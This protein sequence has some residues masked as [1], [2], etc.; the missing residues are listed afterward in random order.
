MNKF[1]LK[2]YTDLFNGTVFGFS[3]KSAEARAEVDNQVIVHAGAQ[4]LGNAD[5]NLVAEKGFSPILVGN[6]LSQSLLEAATASKDITRNEIDRSSSAVTVNGR[7]ETGIK[8]NQVLVIKEELLN[9]GTIPYPIQLD[10]ALTTDDLENP[11]PT[12]KLVDVGAGF[13]KQIDA[14]R[15]LK[16]EYANDAGAVT[17]FN[18]R[19]DA[20]FRQAADIGLVNNSVNPATIRSNYFTPFIVVPEIVAGIGSIYVFGE[21]FNGSGTLI[22]PVDANI[23]ITNYSPYSLQLLGLTVPFRDGGKVLFNTGGTDFIE[24]KTTSDINSRNKSKSG[25]TFGTITTGGTS[26]A[27]PT[28]T[29]ENK[30]S[31]PGT[32]GV[33]GF[34]TGLS[35][36][37]EPD[38]NVLGDINN[39]GGKVTLITG[40]SV[41]VN[42]NLSAKTIEIKAGRDFVLNS[43]GFFSSGGDPKGQ[44]AAEY[45]AMQ[46][47]FFNAPAKNATNIDLSNAA[48]APAFVTAT[49]MTPKTGGTILAGNNAYINAQ[50]LNIN[51]TIQSGRDENNVIIDA[52]QQT[53]IDNFKNRYVP[54][55]NKYLTLSTVAQSGIK[56]LYNAESNRIEVTDTVVRGGYMQ[57]MGRMFSTG[58]GTLKAMDGFGNI[59]ID[60]QT[61]YDLE[62][63][64][65]DTGGEG[66]EGKIVIIDTS[67]AKSSPSTVSIASLNAGSDKVYF[68][69]N[70]S[71]STGEEIVIN[72]T[73]GGLT[74][75]THYFVIEG[76]KEGSQY[77][78]KLATSLSDA[79]ASKALDIGD[80][81]GGSLLGN[82]KPLKT[83]YT[84][85][86]NNVTKKSFYE[87]F[88][89]AGN[90]IE[91][92]PTTT[93]TTGRV[94]P[95]FD[96]TS[97][98]RY[99]WKTGQGILSQITKEYVT[100]SFWGMDS[101]SPDPGQSPDRVE[102][103]VLSNT[104]LIE[105]EYLMMYND[106]VTKSFTFFGKTFT[107][108]EPSF[109]LPN[110]N[111]V[112]A[113]GYKNLTLSETRVDH[114]TFETSSGW[115]PFKTTYLHDVSVYD[116]N[117]K[118][119]H[120]FSVKADFAA[121]V[122][123]IGSDAGTIDVQ[124]VGSIIISNAVNNPKGVT[125]FRST[126]GSIDAQGFGSVNGNTI[127]FNAAK[128]IGV[129]SVIRT[130]L[131]G[132][133]S[134]M[135]AVTTT[136]P[137]NIQEI[138]GTLT[139]TNITTGIDNKNLNSDVTITAENSLVPVNTSALIRGR[140]LILTA[141]T[142]SI[143]AGP[144]L[145][146]LI[147]TDDVR[148]G[149][150]LA[151][152]AQNVAFQQDTG[153]LRV[154]SVVASAG[155]AWLLLGDGGFIDNNKTETYDTRTKDELLAVWTAARLT[156]SAANESLADNIAGYD[157]LK[158]RQYFNAYTNVRL[159]YTT[160]TAS[161]VNTATDT[162]SFAANHGYAN[163]DAVVYEQTEIDNFTITAIDSV[164]DTITFASDPGIENGT[165]VTFNRLS[166]TTQADGLT[167]GMRYFAF[168]V[169]GSTT[170]YKLATS[171]MDANSDNGIDITSTGAG[172]S[173]EVAVSKDSIG[174]LVSG[175]TYYVIVINDSDIKLSPATTSMKTEFDINSVD[176]YV[177]NT[178][179]T[180]GVD[181]VANTLDFAS[182]HGFATG[183][184]VV[185]QQ[186]SAGK[187]S[188][189]GLTSGATYYV[190]KISDTRI[191]LAASM[192][193]AYAATPVVIDL[194]SVGTGAVDTF[195][196][197][198]EVMD[199]TSDAAGSVNTFKTQDFVG[200][201]PKYLWDSGQATYNPDYQY[202]LLVGI[203][204]MDINND[205]LSY[206]KYSVS[207]LTGNTITTTMA[208]GLTTGD[209]VVYQPASGTTAIS[210][211]TPG[212]TY[213]AIVIG[214]SE[215]QLASSATNANSG[216]AIT[217]S[218]S[219]TG[220]HSFV[221]PSQ[222]HGYVTGDT[223][224]YQS[225]AIP[226]NALGGLTNGGS[227]T[228]EVVDANTIKFKASGVVVDLTGTFAGS[229]QLVNDINQY[230]KLKS[231]FQM[232][233]AELGFSIGGGLLSATR[234]TSGT[235]VRIES[236]NVRA[237]GKITVLAEG[238]GGFIGRDSTP[239]TAFLPGMVGIKTIDPGTNTLTM[240]VVARAAGAPVQGS[241]SPIN[242]V[243]SPANHGILDG[244][245]F[246]Y[247]AMAGAP[248]I[249][250][251]VDGTTYYVI[252]AN[253]QTLQL[254]ETL[255]GSV[256]DINGTID[257]VNYPGNYALT[258]PAGTNIDSLTEDQK[259]ALAAAEAGDVAMT[260]QVVSGVL[261]V[262][263][264]VYQRDDFDIQ[265]VSNVITHSTFQTF[266]GSEETINLEQAT[267]GG[268]MIIKVAKSILVAG[269]EL[270][271]IAAPTMILEAKAGTLGT[272]AAPLL[273]D[274]TSDVTADSFVGSSKIATILA[275]PNSQGDSRS[276]AAAKFTYDRRFSPLVIS[277]IN[278][279][280]TISFAKNNPDGTTSTADHGFINGDMVTYE[281]LP[282][283]LRPLGGV[284]G[285][286]KYRVRV[287]DSK[288]IM[289]EA[290]NTLG[291]YSDNKVTGTIPANTGH[292]IMPVD[293]VG[294]ITAR[295]SGDMNLNEVN[296]NMWIGATNSTTGVI[297]LKAVADDAG[298][299]DA[300]P[301]TQ[302]AYWNIYGKEIRLTADYIGTNSNRLDYEQA[303]SPLP[304]F[305]ALSKYDQYVRF[306]VSPISA[307]SGGV[308]STIC[309]LTDV[310]SMFG[311]VD[312][313]SDSEVNVK[314]VEATA[315]LVRINAQFAIKDDNNSAA[316]ITALKGVDLT[317]VKGGIGE[318][319]A[320]EM[321]VGT[322]GT[323]LANA[324]RTVWLTELTEDMN[325]DRITST[326]GTARLMADQSILDWFDDTTV[327]VE[328]VTLDFKALT[329]T[330][331]ASRNYLEVDSSY[332]G[333]V[334]EVLTQ[335]Y[336]GTYMD[337]SVSD[338]NLRNVTS[339]TDVVFLTAAGSIIDIK[340]DT[341]IKVQ[342]YGINLIAR[343]GSIGET[344]NDVETDLQVLTQLTAKAS[345]NVYL[346]EMIGAMRV[347]TIEGTQGIVRLSVNETSTS[348]EDYLMEPGD[349]VVAGVDILIVAADNLFVP[350]GA[351]MTAGKSIT[352]TADNPDA[353]DAGSIITV[354]GT[355][356]SPA[357]SVYGYMQRDTLVATNDASFVLANSKMTR[358]LRAGNIVTVFNLFTLEHAILTGG[359]GN[360]T[361]DIG[362]W[363]GTSVIDG[364]DG[365]DTI[366]ATTNANFVIANDKLQRTGCGDALLSNI[367]YGAFRG[368]IDNNTFDV[369]KWTL[370]GEVH[371]D[372]GID[373]INAANDVNFGLGNT[374]LKRTGMSDLL[375]SGLETGNM[376]GG[377]RDN[378]FTV[379]DWTGGGL[380][381]GGEGTDT[382]IA[383]NDTDF[384]LSDLI[385][386]RGAGKVSLGTLALTNVDDARLTGGKSANKFTVSDWT[387][388]GA[389]AGLVTDLGG[390][391][392]IDSLVAATD[393]DFTL[394]SSMLKRSGGRGDITLFKLTSAA[395]TGG[396]KNN[397]F[398]V[399]G[400]AGTLA[401]AGGTGSD[402]VVWEGKGNVVLGNTLL[403]TTAIKGTMAAI[404]FAE[405]TGDSSSATY[406]LNGWTGKATIE[407]GT[408][409]DTLMVR[410]IS[411]NASLTDTALTV[412]TAQIGTLKDFENAILYG[413]SASQTFN[414]A[415]WTN[416]GSIFGVGGTDTLL[417]T[418]SGAFLMQGTTYTAPSKA[419]W[420]LD[421]VGVNLT[422]SNSRDSFAIR[423]WTGGAVAFN[424]VS[425]HDSL[426]VEANANITIT[427]TLLT[428]GTLKSTINSTSIDS[429]TLIGGASANTFTLTG[430][431]KKASIDGGA[432]KDVLVYAGDTDFLL[433]ANQLVVG[434]GAS[435]VNSSPTGSIAFT[436]AKM[437][438]LTL[439]GGA[440]ANVFT[441][442]GFA[443]T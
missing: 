235:E 380:I 87:E 390:T 139:Y 374:Y 67:T 174:G 282:G 198:R 276:I 212:S 440:S 155:D 35:Q 217:L 400:W 387:G 280:G 373:V 435:S 310:K 23:S 146:A 200:G 210:G 228:V 159:S 57:L 196:S 327:D 241:V 18:A 427:P 140:K 175:S 152:A 215:F 348:G 291:V 242:D 331:G 385:L 197:A 113:Y 39:T 313:T 341:T 81:T 160:K 64:K 404:G 95:S 68:A 401:L 154:D 213:F 425:G 418:G 365:T 102:S 442:S 182:A 248:A 130:D 149:G 107:F 181:L 19:I 17:G 286:K 352:L 79:L 188:I 296:G 325:I 15:S 419:V 238:T 283:T 72:Q 204:G 289:L 414:V 300:I 184:A 173:F 121:S 135:E 52:S 345:A 222:T 202:R 47:R 178:Q 361:F 274:L 315:G 22:S 218:G 294:S 186:T 330:I 162:V 50:Y 349:S 384:L 103:R 364:V 187:D 10:A 394:S 421:K 372:L 318:N 32:A 431:N 119:Y 172:S 70:P 148:L 78:V 273:T 28:I 168:R 134:T 203:T 424:G 62:V 271:T 125:S 410:A 26:A 150:L 122:Q 392:V 110:N 45:K 376:T 56:V 371:G 183:D 275:D 170:A 281:F 91:V 439:T 308:P 112:F 42:G 236:A 206:G 207:G 239:V 74:S 34:V 229:H 136:G 309:Y 367:E 436:L 422:G 20:L 124:S 415:G 93:T 307:G 397:K 73:A 5:V 379:T 123:F 16:A 132:A 409:T 312:Y 389:L 29:V 354:S 335:S 195:T 6:A 346:K 65:L 366:I 316:D 434:K 441:M 76:A 370:P 407:A 180:G 299:L 320:I 111:Q 201:K 268:P 38:I 260:Y 30:W 9:N 333:T 363:T 301:D 86:G 264:T 377:R 2:A 44:W 147:E 1:N 59:T 33:N 167:V 192:M 319:G 141:T 338:M 267:S 288:K 179:T 262:M 382:L 368:G 138:A 137:I 290:A 208:H 337:E 403:T 396:T 190:I 323:V 336:L 256:V 254:S 399:S 49:Y 270:V 381:D 253:G 161:T 14:L 88:N 104:P 326:I 324:L 360:N 351:S 261:G 263:F 77:W 51:G 83:V 249:P 63:R 416:T 4:V 214:S 357:N 58:N 116:R 233:E 411:T 194:S 224:T 209:R 41:I 328:A 250:G 252:N 426:L 27:D 164:A 272:T 66:I 413:T 243:L 191:K 144:E 75:G 342:G 227:Y 302:N 298:I 420:T 43:D 225:L 226:A 53:R 230:T 259:V 340:N 40:G 211:L 31:S 358:T 362:G 189:G 269:T 287:I 96:T 55:G 142:G 216:T 220:N 244:T 429:L 199:L 391:T 311:N 428:I 321:E 145:P 37:P 443:G 101:W 13:A 219:L 85:V 21:N 169:S 405:I 131:L 297:R 158:T 255:N 94:A 329:G 344:R 347:V 257:T 332:R 3:D 305:Y 232:S 98:M 237:G 156:G 166:G 46:S 143:G 12:V 343:A 378:T 292:V 383:V 118:D 84:R 171:L 266:L 11:S 54:G 293:G 314:K 398:D 402:T 375:L 8:R 437:E 205:T 395:L 356:T 359:V 234:T 133:S 61:T 105:G 151:Y 408:G 153:N 114:Y 423:T 278:S 438:T 176:G 69:S 97:G 251:L 277:V 60:N 258:I 417:D 433:T 304:T 129:N 240:A 100:S 128:G 163:G 115:G 303:A 25:A 108:S 99:V 334:G 245:V 90:V 355:F 353:D 185:Y 223:V 386:T 48:N 127:Q 265:A 193:D 126:A 339:L 322:T 231:R 80:A 430:W 92:S 165:M 106:Q 285:A 393:S 221:D 71:L 369:T 109:G 120:T 7:V 177:F 317:S 412:G 36:I 89:A 24:V 284:V 295:S 117:T 246:V 350:E 432:G 82:Y 406:D 388:T 157:T 306:A 247:R 279:D